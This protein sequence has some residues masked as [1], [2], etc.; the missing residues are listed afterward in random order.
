M[1]KTNYSDIIGKAG[2]LKAAGKKWHFHLLNKSCV[3]N[4]NKGQFTIVLENEETGENFYTLFEEKPLPESKKLAD[5]SYGEGFLDYKDGGDNPGEGPNPEFE[6]LL[7]RA[8][9]CMAQNIAWHNHHLY[10]ECIYNTHPGK[11][12]IVFEEEVSARTMTAV[13]S[14][15]PKADLVAIETLLYAELE[16]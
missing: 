1:E 13:Y 6:T 9:V 2:D 14:R 8:K 5:L 15:K 4:K 10:P 16:E 7:A 11:H 3:F 12:C